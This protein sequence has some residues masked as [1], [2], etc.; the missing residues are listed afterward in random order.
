M[1]AARRGLGTR[2]RTSRPSRGPSTP[3]P[4]A[5][6]SWGAGWL[7]R[8]AKSKPPAVHAPGCRGP[9]ARGDRRWEAVE[10]PAP[11][12][13][14][15]GTRVEP[16]CGRRCASPSESRDAGTAPSSPG[17]TGVRTQ[18]CAPRLSQ[19]HSQQQQQVAATRPSV[20]GQTN[21]TWSMRTVERYSALKRTDVLTPAATWLNRRRR[22]E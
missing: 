8:T 1:A 10:N 3:T 18:G 20:D 2:D 21:K 19:R 6:G 13:R 5:A 17:R 9:K 22:A 16:L 7:R 15:V 14:L 12:A 11:R 4:L